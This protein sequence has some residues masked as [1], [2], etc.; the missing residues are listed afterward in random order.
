MRPAPRAATDLDTVL[1]V[2]PRI[3]LEPGTVEEAAAD[4]RALAGDGLSVT[5]VGGGTDLELGAHRLGTAQRHDH[6]VTGAAVESQLWH[7]I[8]AT[9][10]HPHRHPVGLAHPG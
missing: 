4:L 5:F 8:H 3:A 2:R 10:V 1:G 9:G 7:A 6:Q